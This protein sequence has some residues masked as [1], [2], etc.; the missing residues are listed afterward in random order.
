MTASGVAAAAA[1][2]NALKTRTEYE[3]VLVTGSD[4]CYHFIA[5][6]RA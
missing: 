2:D 6:L 4:Y 5:G 1:L 3:I